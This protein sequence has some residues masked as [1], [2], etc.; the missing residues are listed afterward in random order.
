MPEWQIWIG[1]PVIIAGKKEVRSQ[2]VPKIGT[3]RS[4]MYDVFLDADK[5]KQI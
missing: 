2:I 3:V 5:T 1:E 4:E